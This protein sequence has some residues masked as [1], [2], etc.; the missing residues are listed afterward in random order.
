MGP[1]AR[2]IEEKNPDAATR[3]K[4]V[5]EIET[6]FAAVADP[7]SGEVRLQGTIFLVSARRPA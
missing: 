6:A 1:T 7:G 5:R 4:L 3:Q 2:L